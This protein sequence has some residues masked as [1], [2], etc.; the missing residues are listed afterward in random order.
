MQIGSNPIAQTAVNAIRQANTAISTASERISTGLRINRASDDPAGMLIGNKLK[1]QITSLAKASDNVNQG[2]AMTQV[3]DSAYTKIIDL[4]NE[5]RTTALA[6]SDSDYFSSVGTQINT[7]IKGIDSVIADATYNG[8]NLL[9]E[10]GTFSIQYGTSSASSADLSF[11]AVTRT[12]DSDSDT[13]DLG[14]SSVSWTSSTSAS[15]INSTFVDT[16]DAAL[17]EI[18]T[19]QGENAAQV[20]WMEAQSDFSTA[21]STVYSAAYGRVMSADLAQET[22][23]LASAQVQRDGATAML[24]QANAMNKE[25]VGYLL[26]SVSA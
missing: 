18:E 7:Y 17:T 25:I 11:T 24:A 8:N 2:L 14:L 23:N 5:M 13:T 9:S 3:A 12:T 16:I 26:K 20:S 10:G 1:T 4:L 19:L 21:L 6:A 22:A 15:T